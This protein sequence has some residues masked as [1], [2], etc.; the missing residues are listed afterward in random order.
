MVGLSRPDSNA[1]LSSDVALSHCSS[2]ASLHEPSQVPWP[3][4]LVNHQ[5]THGLL[6]SIAVSPLGD[7]Y[8]Q[9][10]VMYIHAAL[11]HAE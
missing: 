5:L 3:S 4:I 11:L 7:S 9:G 10:P 1:F 8:G 6:L 2:Y